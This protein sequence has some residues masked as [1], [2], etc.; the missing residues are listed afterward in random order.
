MIFP[1]D[2]CEDAVMAVVAG[3]GVQRGQQE[4][5][6]GQLE[7]ERLE[8]H[9]PGG[10]DRGVG[11]IRQPQRRGQVD[12]VRSGGRRYDIRAGNQGADS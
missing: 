12:R 2:R 11:D 7:R 8:N 4:G 9:R 10:P 5:P 6:G 1:E 3:T